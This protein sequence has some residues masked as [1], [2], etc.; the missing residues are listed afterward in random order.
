MKR[1]LAVPQKWRLFFHGFYGN[2]GKRHCLLCGNSFPQP[3]K[4][5][6][7]K[8]K[9]GN[10]TFAVFEM[11]QLSVHKQ[12]VARQ[13]AGFSVTDDYSQ[14]WELKRYRHCVPSMQKVSWPWT[15]YHAR[16]SIQNANM[17]IRKFTGK[18]Y[19]YNVHVM[20]HRHTLSPY[21]LQSQWQ[22]GLIIKYKLQLRIH[23]RLVWSQMPYMIRCLDSTKHAS[24][25]T[26]C[27]WISISV[28]HISKEPCHAL[29][30]SAMQH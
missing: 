21:S 4:F 29:G 17:K 24:S 13:V 9:E 25:H 28:I 20:F 14:N 27:V 26:S 2:G 11:L 10:A 1:F 7:W 6:W 18:T 23:I 8:L 3:P 19:T 15:S 12:V 22:A 5:S 30:E 16:S